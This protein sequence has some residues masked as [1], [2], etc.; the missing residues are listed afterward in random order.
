MS[1]EVGDK[2]IDL[3]Y[4]EGI[5][6]SIDIAAEY[7]ILV[8]FDHESEQEVYTKDGKD[9][10]FNP[11]PSLYHAEG[12]VPPS[13]DEPERKK[14]YHF[15]PFDK[16]LV[17]DTLEEEWKPAFFSYYS[18]GNRNPYHTIMLNGWQYCI[19]Y[20]GNEDKVGKVTE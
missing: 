6:S 17:R 3:R 13:C 8:Y 19:P 5:I 12:F 10:H 7:P 11:Y 1:F 9:D 2:V 16:V 4:G 18:K 15:K 20:E 14:E